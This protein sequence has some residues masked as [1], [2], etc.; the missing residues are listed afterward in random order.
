MGALEGRGL[1]Q[2]VPVKLPVACEGEVTV[3]FEAPGAEVQ[4][5]LVGGRRLHQRRDGLRLGAPAIE[6]EGQQEDQGEEDV[7]HSVSLRRGY[8]NGAA[9]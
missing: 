2:L 9:G 7:R 5:P 3:P 6:A 8:C 1:Q 4:N